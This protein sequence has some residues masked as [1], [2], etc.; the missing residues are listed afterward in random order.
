MEKIPNFDQM[1]IPTLEI[2][3]QCQT[4]MRIEE[5]D[6]QIIKKMG[7]GYSIHEKKHLDTHQS[8]FSYR[9]A[10]ARTYL[11]KYGVIDNPER[12]IWKINDLYRGE[13]L[14]ANDIV[15]AVRE[16]RKFIPKIEIANHFDVKSHNEKLLKSLSKKYNKRKI[17]LFLGAGVSMAS[18]MP[19]WDT[20]VARFLVNRFR[21]ENKEIDDEVAKKLIELEKM[22]R[23]NSLISQTRFIKQNMTLEKYFE[24]LTDALYQEK[25]IIDL[26]VPLLNSLIKM[27]RNRNNIYI[28]K[29]VTFN[30]DN[31]IERKLEEK[32]VYFKT[33]ADH[34]EDIDRDAVYIYHVHG[35]LDSELKPDEINEKEIIFSE[36]EYHKMYNNPYHWSN[37][38]QVNA[39][40][41]NTCLFIGCS[42]SD[43]NMRR[44]LDVAKEENEIKHYAI[45]KKE[46]I[47]CPD[48]M[49]VTD[50][51][52]K[53]YNEFYLSNKNDYFNSLGIHVIWVEDYN[54]IPKIIEQ[55]MFP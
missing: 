6:E 30:F 51:A 40:R 29:I 8:E 12:S 45:L 32:D 34:I 35:F 9:A 1:I 26:D 4:E 17:S 36:E 2:L 25:D 47:K 49:S 22:N 38:I 24:I 16:N 31:I 55:I 33:C 52:Y 53:I 41:E 42:L 19:S 18:H 39:L 13:K 11:K 3:Y 15:S 27:I 14:E 10:W 7:L 28:K 21:E 54:D 23:E 50:S 43:P 37:M 20:L 5:I 48:G 44:L 46:D